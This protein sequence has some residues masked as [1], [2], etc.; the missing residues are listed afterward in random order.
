MREGWGR[1]GGL[2]NHRHTWAVFRHRVGQAKSGE[3]H[4]GRGVIWLT[5]RQI[6][7]YG[8]ERCGFQL[9]TL[10]SL[11]YHLNDFHPLILKDCLR[12]YI[13]RTSVST[14]CCSRAEALPTRSLE[15]SY[16]VSLFCEQ[17]NF[18]SLSP[19]WSSLLWEVIRFW[20]SQVYQSAK[21]GEKIQVKCSLRRKNIF[22]FPNSRCCCTV[23]VH[24]IKPSSLNVRFLLFLSEYTVWGDRF[25]S[26]LPMLLCSVIYPKAWWLFLTLWAL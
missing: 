23:P 9:L 26:S 12:M 17:E 24:T 4:P 6:G 22:C 7:L 19:P 3:S 16:L 20:N 8:E 18:Q 13:Y 10:L 5:G 11:P 21:L 2:G 14:S 1:K 15:I 25:H